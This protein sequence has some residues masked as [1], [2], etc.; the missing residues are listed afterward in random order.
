MSLA[1][2]V[3]DET[4][5]GRKARRAFSKKKIPSNMGE[6]TELDERRCDQKRKESKTP[7]DGRPLFCDLI[8]RRGR[9]PSL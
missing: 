6:Q 2:L 5:R 8:L 9:H 7:T 3:E 1:G 4:R